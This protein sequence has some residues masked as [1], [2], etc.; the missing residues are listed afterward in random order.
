[1]IPTILLC[2]FVSTWM[3]CISPCFP[4][5]QLSYELSLSSCACAYDTHSIFRQIHKKIVISQLQPWLK[6]SL[7]RFMS[8]WVCVCVCCRWLWRDKSWFEFQ[9]EG[10]SWNVTTHL[11]LSFFFFLHIFRISNR[12][13]TWPKFGWFVV[14]LWNEH[15][16]LFGFRCLFF[17]FHFQSTSLHFNV[18]RT[19]IICREH[20]L[21]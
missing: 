15:H 2:V 12:Q 8:L 11:L 20:F 17:I 5:D 14:K 10:S 21:E 4:W 16:K 3:E 19:P 7:I 18:H 6:F 9:I 1:M 13:L